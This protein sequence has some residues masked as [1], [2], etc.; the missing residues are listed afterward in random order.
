MRCLDTLGQSLNDENEHQNENNLLQFSGYIVAADAQ[1][2]E[3]DYDETH[4][5]SATFV[6]QRTKASTELFMSAFIKQRTL[7]T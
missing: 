4:P 6:N 1:H 7:T 2:Q 5:R 3:E